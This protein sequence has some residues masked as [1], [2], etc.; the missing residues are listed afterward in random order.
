MQIGII[1]DSH[2][3]VTH[4][5]WV[6]RRFKEM[7]IS[8]VLHAGDYCSPFS[9]LPFQGLRL[10]GVFGNNDGDHYRLQQK[11]REINGDIHNEFYAAEYEGKH[12]AL[13]HGTQYAITDALLHC[14]T[15]DLVIT[16]H[17]HAPVQK[18][19]GKTLHINPGT[20][21]GFEAQPTFASYDFATGESKIHT[22][23]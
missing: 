20:L 2:D 11:F 10:I 13:Y 15:Y 9:I 8:T 12:V 21:H 18:Q 4:C 23:I 16:G 17:T 1:S 22:L 6:A 19:V 5:N 14:G 3:H 7:H